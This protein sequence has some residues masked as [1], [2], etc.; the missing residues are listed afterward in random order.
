MRIM[1]IMW[2][3]AFGLARDAHE[4]LFVVALRI[5][6]ETRNVSVRGGH[7]VILYVVYI[8]FPTEWAAVGDTD[9]QSRHVVL[10]APTAGE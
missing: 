3:P 7:L 1:W 9:P 5:K 2:P 10:A 6:N 8:K 4:A